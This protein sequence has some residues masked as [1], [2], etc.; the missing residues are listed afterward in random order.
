MNPRLIFGLTLVSL[1]AL[2]IGLAI[3]A[4]P[5]RLTLI[6]SLL[7][8]GPI[9]VSAL[10]LTPDR[11]T[12]PYRF[13]YCLFVVAVAAKFLWP[14]FAY[15]PIGALP[16]KNPQ[17]WIWALCILYWAYSLSINGELRR[18][19]ATRLMGSR[20]AWLLGMLIAW[21]LT[22]TT[23]SESIPT[24]LYVMLVELFD[25]LPAFLFALTWVRDER[26]ARTLALT[27]MVTALLIGVIA[28]AEF[29]L[30][31]NVFLKM[32]P[33]DIENEAFLRAAV[34]GKLRGGA[35]RVQASFN[36]PLLLAQF[37]V[38]VLPLAVCVATAA[39]KRTT[40]AFSGVVFIVLLGL[41]LASR[42]RT[43]VAVAALVIALSF[44]MG[45]WNGMRDK[46]SGTRKP[47]IS[48]IGLLAGVAVLVSVFA[49]IAVLT[50]GRTAEEAG[51]S[52]ARVIM[53]Q[54][55]VDAAAVKPILGYGPGVGN[56]MAA[57]FSSSG[58][59]SLDSY[60]LTQMLEAGVPAMLLYTGLIG[61]GAFQVL[62]HFRLGEQESVGVSRVRAAW[63]LCIIAFGVSSTVLSTPHNMPLFF[64]ALGVVVAL[65][66]VRKRNAFSPRG[67]NGRLI[68]P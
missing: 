38:C 66:P 2:T 50:Q 20:V 29:A 65:A 48:A 11:R 6:L 64:L 32:V 62:R 30:K 49:L 23:F 47:L 31:A 19:L 60:F 37:T 63:G 61:I 14:N 36:H 10:L 8:L 46:K 7:I 51:S 34:E 18:R 59:A 54:R 67:A 53:F 33:G 55:A 27:L 41:L 16:S 24:S 22:A 12:V 57:L 42:T 68:R 4:V 43:A 58:A 9:A 35:Y 26:D 52:L 28:T 25:Y 15:I 1:A 21:R 17:R 56:Y 44:L 39:T 3:A 40:Q 5:M 13:I 45:A